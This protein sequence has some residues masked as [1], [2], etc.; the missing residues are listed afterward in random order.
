M[1]AW[2]TLFHLLIRLWR[3]AVWVLKGGEDTALEFFLKISINLALE[4]T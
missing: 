2:K 4:F 3:G 1:I